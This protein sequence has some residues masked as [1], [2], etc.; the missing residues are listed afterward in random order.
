MAPVGPPVGG[1]SP[2]LDE[3]SVEGIS[4]P[5]KA[6]DTGQFFFA[7]S[8]CSRNARSSSPGT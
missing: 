3:P 2:L 1:H 5:V 7:V 8:A 6:I 4:T